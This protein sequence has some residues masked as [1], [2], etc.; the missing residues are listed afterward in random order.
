MESEGKVKGPHLA[1]FYGFLGGC[2]DP[3]ASQ[4]PAHDAMMSE[5]TR[6]SFFFP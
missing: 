5:L 3:V 2:I 1:G 6:V 4:Q